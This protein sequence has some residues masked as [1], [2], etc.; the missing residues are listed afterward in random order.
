MSIYYKDSRPDLDSLHLMEMNEEHKTK[1]GKTEAKS[2][3]RKR[4]PK[5]VI[6]NTLAMKKSGTDKSSTSN[7]RGPPILSFVKEMG[8]DVK[9][10]SKKRKTKEKEKFKGN[11]FSRKM[12]KKQGWEEGLG[13]GVKNRGIASA[14]DGETDGQTTRAGLGYKEK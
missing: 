11:E 4:K 6:Q 13:L 1:D 2:V 9:E 5:T 8:V 3:F 14:I 10:T 12:M 7:R